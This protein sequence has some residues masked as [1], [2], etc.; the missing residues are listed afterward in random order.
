M[1]SPPNPR[2]YIFIRHIPLT[3]TAGSIPRRDKKERTKTKWIGAEGELM[4]R[5]KEQTIEG[6]TKETGNGPNQATRPFGHLLR[7]T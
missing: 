3:T 2:K 1:S 4:A 6:R 7:P 5:R